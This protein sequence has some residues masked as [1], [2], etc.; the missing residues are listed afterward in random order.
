MDNETDWDISILKKSGSVYAGHCV[1]NTI[2]TNMNRA[3]PTDGFV[4]QTVV[5]Y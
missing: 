5:T 2:F 1:R 3:L 4:D